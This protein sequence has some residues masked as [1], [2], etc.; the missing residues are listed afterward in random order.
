MP[1]P[2]LHIFASTNA[3]IAGETLYTASRNCSSIG[4]FHRDSLALWGVWAVLHSSK[5][6]ETTASLSL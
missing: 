4:A 1:G 5:V 2:Q 3:D 6:S